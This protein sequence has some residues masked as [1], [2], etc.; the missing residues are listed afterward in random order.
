MNPKKIIIVG[1]SSG[2]GAAVAGIYVR[3]G[4]LVAVTGRRENLL[5]ELK[6]KY[7][8]QL[9]TSCFDVMGNNNEA[10]IQELIEELGGLD[11]LI[12]NAGYGRFSEELDLN[13]EQITIQTNVNGF[14]GIVGYAF[15]FFVKQGYGQIALTSSVAALRGNSRAP[16]YSASKSFM[17]IYAEGLSIKAGK[18]NKEI[19]IT[20]L[21]PGFLDTK[22]GEGIKRF[23][24]VSTE[25]AARQIVKAIG[26]KKRVAYI[27]PRWRLVAWI[28]K[29]LPYFIYSRIV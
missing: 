20:D 24:V 4:D 9:I 12:Y 18:L 5:M 11:L 21:R 28:L 14:A 23:W 2:I 29:N 10:Y 26:S 22:T 19:V 13:K 27:S 16:A 6:N 25:L 7:G 1:A 15:N 3:N 8:N 17:S